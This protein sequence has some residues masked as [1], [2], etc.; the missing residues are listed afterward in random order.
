MSHC[1]KRRRRLYCE[2]WAAKLSSKSFGQELEKIWTTKFNLT[3]FNDNQENELNYLIFEKFY[4]IN[5]F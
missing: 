3:T 4:L 5:N 2:T 1:A